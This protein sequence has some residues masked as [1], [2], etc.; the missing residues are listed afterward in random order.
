MKG[1]LDLG[2]SNHMSAKYP[3]IQVSGYHIPIPNSSP[4]GSVGS[5]LRQ[6]PGTLPETIESDPLC[7]KD[8]FQNKSVA[9]SYPYIM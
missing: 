1:K 4:V 3:D 2:P 8:L 6:A 9:Y 7:I 5:T